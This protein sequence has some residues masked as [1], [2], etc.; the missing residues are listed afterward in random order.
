VLWEAD[1]GRAVGAGDH[2]AIPDGLVRAAVDEDGAL[3]GQHRDD[4][5]VDMGQGLE[6]Q[7]V[8]DPE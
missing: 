7:G 6:Q 5:G 8:L 3:V 1:D 2:T 4:R